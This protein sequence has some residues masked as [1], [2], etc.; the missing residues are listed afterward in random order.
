V[1]IADIVGLNAE[2]HAAI[3]HAGPGPAI[4][5]A[6]HRRGSPVPSD[7]ADA[8]ARGMREANRTI[9]RS[10]ILLDPANVT[11]NLQVERIV[12]CA[13]NAS[14]LIFSAPADLQSA[15]ESTLGT[16][17]LEALRRSLCERDP[18]V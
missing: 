1:D 18:G 15:M 4:L 12:R 3:R 2:V 5:Y 13:G 7:V 10:A 17:E 8:W 11:F 14:R 16:S 9:V 6:D